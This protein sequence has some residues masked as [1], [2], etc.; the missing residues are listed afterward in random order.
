MN[1]AFNPSK[2]FFFAHFTCIANAFFELI[3]G[4]LKEWVV[5][6]NAWRAL[7]WLFCR[8]LFHH[9]LSFL[10]TRIFAQCLPPCK[11]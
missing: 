9:V 8:R 4:I 6:L 10:L 3:I 5:Q 11:H 7:L 2:G 1:D